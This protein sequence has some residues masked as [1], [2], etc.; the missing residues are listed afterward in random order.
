M[1]QNCS[2]SDGLV[3]RLAPKDVHYNN[4]PAN[5]PPP[6]L[7]KARIIGRISNVDV[8]THQEVVLE[9]GCLKEAPLTSSLDC[10]N[11]IK[12]ANWC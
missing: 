6:L 9:E 7:D 1:T 4:P 10:T 11:Q 8:V 5:F 2:P 3:G 12:W